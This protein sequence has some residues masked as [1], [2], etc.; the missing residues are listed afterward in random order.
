MTLSP[1]KVAAYAQ[2]EEAIAN[3]TNVFS[4]SN[5]S[6][7]GKGVI[8]GFLLLI[9]EISP[10]EDDEDEE[11]MM[12]TLGIYTRRGQNPLLSCGLARDYMSVYDTV[13]ED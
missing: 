10:K 6:N 12:A 2:L 9:S 1:E 5:D 11:E 4:G 8:T 3:I 7:C 13:R